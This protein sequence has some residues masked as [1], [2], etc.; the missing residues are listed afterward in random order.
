MAYERKSL[1]EPLIPL[2]RKNHCWHLG[3]S[4]IFHVSMKYVSIFKD[5]DLTVHSGLQPLYCDYPSASLTEL[6]EGFMAP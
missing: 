6:N 5:Y 4:R 1:K 2:P 3:I